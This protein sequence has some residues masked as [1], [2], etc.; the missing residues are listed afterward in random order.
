MDD[1]AFLVCAVLH[2]RAHQA[3]EGYIHSSP[4][5]LPSHDLLFNIL[6]YTSNGLPSLASWPGA[7]SPFPTSPVCVVEIPSTSAAPHTFHTTND[8]KQTH[9]GPS[10]HVNPLS[11]SDSD[12]EGSA[13]VHPRPARK[14][15]RP[16]FIAPISPV[17]ALRRTVCVLG[18]Y[19]PCGMATVGSDGRKTCRGSGSPAGG[20]AVGPLALYV[21]FTC[22]P[23]G[24]SLASC[25]VNYSTPLYDYRTEYL[26]S[27]QQQQ[28]AG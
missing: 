8:V 3:V 9:Q 16:A 23:R 4:F 22:E 20:R 27:Q 28:R 15:A 13:R 18:L 12:R 11:S 19:G 7:L 2:S 5:I 21:G 24:R 26:L 14:A 17:G 1:S 6:I 25:H 10:P